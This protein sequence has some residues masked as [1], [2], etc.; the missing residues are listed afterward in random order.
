MAPQA[1]AVDRGGELGTMRAT[2]AVGRF[3]GTTADGRSETVASYPFTIRN[4]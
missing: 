4:H 1:R 2:L 3:S